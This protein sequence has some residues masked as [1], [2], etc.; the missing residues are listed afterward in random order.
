MIHLLLIIYVTH[1]G[2]GLKFVINSYGNMIT[3]S[4]NYISLSA[5]PDSQKKGRVQNKDW[6][7]GPVDSWTRGLFFFK[8][9][10]KCEKSTAELDM[11]SIFV[12]CAMPHCHKKGRF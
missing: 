2:H 11:D 4:R 10:L 7:R 1:T 5:V 12:L 3:T 8:I 9:L 6:T